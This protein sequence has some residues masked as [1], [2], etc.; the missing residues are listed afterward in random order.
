MAFNINEIK[1]QMVFDG[2]RPSL[3]QVTLQNPAN[4]VA[5]IK[6]SFMCE[7]TAL[8]LCDVGDIPVPYFGRFIKLAGNR[9]Y[10]DWRVTVMNDED[11]LIRNALEEWSN[12]I[13]TFQGNIRS[14]ST[15]SPLLYKSQAQVIQ[16]SKTGVPI[17]TYQFNGIFPKQISEI[18]LNW[19]TQNQIERFAVT[20]A[21]DYWEISGGITGNSGGV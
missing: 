18:E 17:R 21:V 16:Y 11:F 20:F 5:D 1:S 9:N 4:S 12:R 13:N 2:A 8:P 3:F 7:A 19:A 14:F 10:A 15:A 6:F